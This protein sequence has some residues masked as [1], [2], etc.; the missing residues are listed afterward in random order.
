MSQALYPLQV[1]LSI[2]KL[3]TQ[4]GLCFTCVFL[5]NGGIGDKFMWFASLQMWWEEENV[6]L[7]EWGSCEKRGERL[8]WRFLEKG[9]KI[10]YPPPP[11][12]PPPCSLRT[13]SMKNGGQVQKLRWHSHAL[14]M[15][16]T[17]TTLSK[18]RILDSH[19]QKSVTDNSHTGH[20]NYL[21][22]PESRLPR[23]ALWC[24]NHENTSDRKSHPWAPLQ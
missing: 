2:L 24:K 6:E 15:R 19:C 12:I 11:P 20:T 18:I 16:V 10:C 22:L 14:S 1:Y 21:F 3:V 23:K 8:W 13:Q 5:K 7:S 9:R 4:I 17:G